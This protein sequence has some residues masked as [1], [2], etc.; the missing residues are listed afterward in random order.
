M[1]TASLRPRFRNRSRGGWRS[2]SGT[3][4][5]FGFVERPFRLP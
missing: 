1:A 2:M 5:W 3:D 4:N